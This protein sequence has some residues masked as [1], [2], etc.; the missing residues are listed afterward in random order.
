MALTTYLFCTIFVKLTNPK[1]LTGYGENMNRALTKINIGSLHSTIYMI[2][3]K[4]KL[5]RARRTSEIFLIQ[6]FHI[7]LL[8]FFFYI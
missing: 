2:N 8:I 4:R 7:Q 3:L 5:K 6:S 1:I